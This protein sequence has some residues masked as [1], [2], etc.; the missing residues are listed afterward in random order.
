MHVALATPFPSPHPLLPQTNRLAR[1]R[2][3]WLK[4]RISPSSPALATNG[5]QHASAVTG[6]EW[7]SGKKNCA[8]WRSLT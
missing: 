7:R 4:T 5:S 8:A 1:V 3:R 6:A 2:T